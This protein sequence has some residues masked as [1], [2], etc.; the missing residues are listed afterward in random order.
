M[1]QPINIQSFC[2]LHKFFVCSQLMNFC[3]NSFANEF[4][5]NKWKLGRGQRIFPLNAL[6]MMPS[7]A[8]F[9]FFCHF[10][11]CCTIKAVHFWMWINSICASTDNQKKQNNDSQRER[12]REWIGKKNKSADNV[13][14]K[15]VVAVDTGPRLPVALCTW[16]T[17]TA[18]NLHTLCVK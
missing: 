14:M 8:F 12:E 1:L 15:W 17:Q 2:T 5:T 16:H 13:W 18:C 7:L 11:Y 4:A 10:C 6:R 3:V 9:Y